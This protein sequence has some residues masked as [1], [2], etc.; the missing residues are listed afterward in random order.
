M[1]ENID[2][3]RYAMRT[4]CKACGGTVGRLVEKTGQ[5]TVRCIACDAYCYCAPKTE[6]GREARTARTVH[7]G[8]RPKDRALILERDGHRCVLCKADDV[9]LHIGHV[10]SV[11]AG[12]VTGLTDAEINDEENLI[13]QCEECNLGQG[14]QPIPLRVAIAILRARISWRDREASK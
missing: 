2:R 10:V 12:L 1:T 8:I 9:R 13:A 11:E 14:A 6:T 5:D 7:K 3:E 4:P